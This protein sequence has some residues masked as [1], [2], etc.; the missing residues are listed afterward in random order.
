MPEW[1]E[2]EDFSTWQ[3]SSQLEEYEM[4]VEYGFVFINF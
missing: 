2:V 4:V 3:G 1:P